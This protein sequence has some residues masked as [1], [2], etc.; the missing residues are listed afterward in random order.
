MKLN[1]QGKTYQFSDD[2]LD[3][4]DL[5]DIEELT[6][7]ATA[8]WQEA[9][10]KGSGRALTALVWIL[11]RKEEP[12]LEYKAVRFKLSEISLEND[13]EPGKED[14]TEAPSETS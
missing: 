9:L 1:V 14:G 10:F 13:E 11:R 5:I 6:G 2:D 3:N 12:G 7:L 8:D 4:V